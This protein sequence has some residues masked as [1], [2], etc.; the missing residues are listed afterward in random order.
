MNFA[1][2]VGVSR[3][4]GQS[5]VEFV[6]NQMDALGIGA[7]LKQVTRNKKG[8]RL[9][10]PPS[11]L[12]PDAVIEPPEPTYQFGCATLPNTPDPRTRA[13]RIK[14]GLSDPNGPKKKRKPK[15]QTT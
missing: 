4:S 1:Y 14:L 3:L 13:E 11:R 10:L 7:D 2:A 8:K 9:F 6:R 12:N 5:A 15:V